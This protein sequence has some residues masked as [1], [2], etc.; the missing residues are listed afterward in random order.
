MTVQSKGEEK[1]HKIE[2]YKQKNQQNLETLLDTITDLLFILNSEGKI[3]YVNS[4]VIERLKYTKEELIGM[5]VLQIHPPDLREK[6]AEII[7]NM[8]SGKTSICPIPILS[9]D[10]ELIQVE[11]KVVQGEWNG[12]PVLIGI[13]RDISERNKVEDALREREKRYRSLFERTNDA[14]FLIGLDGRYIEVNQQAAD[15]LG[16]KI[17]ELKNVHYKQMIDE[18][19]YENSDSKLESLLNG[20]ILP[21]YQRIFKKK[22]GTEFP[23]EINVAM[24]FD[25]DGTPLHIQSIVRDITERK[26]WEE[27]LQRMNVELQKFA[28]V[29]SH[30]LK[31]P[32][33]GVNCLASSLLLNHSDKLDKDDKN[34][35]KMMMDQL[36][37]MNAL[38]EGILE[39]SRIGR[40]QERQI[41]FKIQDLLSDILK[42]LNPPDHIQINL[43]TDLP[44]LHGE[45]TRFF[46]VFQN[47]I[48]NAIK[49]MDKSEGL[50]RIGHKDKGRHWEFYVSDNGPGIETKY[51]NKIFQLFQTLAPRDETES[52]GVGLAI[53]KKVV[54]NYGGKVGLKS[55]VGAGSTFFF[56]IPKKK[57]HR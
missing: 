26:Q 43:E 41:T 45:R 11:T 48:S 25:K 42:L 2:E 24:V 17:D 38:I 16:Y 55:K 8:L 36:K 30:D 44:T 37:N 20:D 32:L 51:H 47:L 33:R 7:K 50:I 15:M 13:S 34:R 19:E 57:N 29:V 6:A 10:G 40:V 22:D 3:V 54:E 18:K 35:L 56:T 28:Y 53:V 52:T 9:K 46:Q 12:Q 31:A 5:E 49:F 39:Y 21:V 1:G 23:G 4:I 27:D 14:V